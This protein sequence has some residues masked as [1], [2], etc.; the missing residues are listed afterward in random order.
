[1]QII[2]RDGSRQEFNKQKIARVVHSAGLS[3]EESHVLANKIEEW[4]KKQA[5][6]NKKVNSLEIKDQVSKLLKQENEYA[7]GLYSWYENIKSKN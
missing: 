7:W 2:K 1:M 4:I 5:S 6:E 3:Q